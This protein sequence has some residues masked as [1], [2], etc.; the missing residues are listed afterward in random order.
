VKN[1]SA[2]LI[3]MLRVLIQDE[4]K[5]RMPL[6]WCNG[7]WVLWAGSCWGVW[8]SLCLWVLHVFFFLFI[9]HVLVSFLY[10]TCM[11]GDAFT[12]LINFCT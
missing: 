4:A 1:L 7:L 6:L 5:A 8:V 3:M 10:T 9:F 11:L 12:F 2:R